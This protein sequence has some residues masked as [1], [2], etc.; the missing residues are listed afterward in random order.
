MTTVEIAAGQSFKIPLDIVK[1]GSILCISFQT[2][3]AQ[4][5]DITFGLYMA[6]DQSQFQG[7][8]DNSMTKKLGAMMESNPAYA[9]AKKPDG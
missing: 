4:G 5:G 2:L 7:K 3:V 9:T 6:S 1:P 8:V